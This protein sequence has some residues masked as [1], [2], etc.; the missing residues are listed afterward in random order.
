MKTTDIKQLSGEA[1][2]DIPVIGRGDVISGEAQPSLI[3][4]TKPNNWDIG[5]RRAWIIVLLY[6]KN[7]SLY[8]TCSDLSY[9][10]FD[11]FSYLKLDSNNNFFCFTLIL[12]I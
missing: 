8:P 9:I 4:F 1:V 6:P 10:Q 2:S 3:W 12:I 5:N 11:I 7:T